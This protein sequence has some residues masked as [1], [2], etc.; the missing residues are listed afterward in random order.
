MN[1]KLSVIIPSNKEIFLKKTIEEL[2]TKSEED[3]EVI[4]V[5]DG[6]YPP[7]DEIIEDDR[8]IYLHMG[9]GGGMRRAIN[10]GVSIAK[11]NY[12]M[13]IDGHCMVDQGFDKKLKADCE[14]N[15][16]V[17]PRRKRLDA[18]LWT[19]QDVGKPDVDYEFISFP[20]W[21]PD[22]VGIHGTIWTERIV[23]RMNDPKYDIDE[24]PTFQGSCWFTTKKHFE[25]VIGEMQEEG[26]GS[27][28]GEPQ[29]ISMKTWL[30]GGKVM[31]NKK[32]WYAHLH[33]GKKYGR[34]YFIDKKELVAGNAYS[35]DYW[36]N[37]RFPK[38][39]HTMEWFVNEKFPDM[40]TWV[41]EWK[42]IC[43]KNGLIK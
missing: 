4:A 34:G 41:P 11:G 5:L 29:E 43:I 18:E 21:K 39:I 30:S 19:I 10:A 26:Y 38:A 33:K 2:L 15:W 40:P 31:I 12:I 1:N 36:M 7:A 9:A 14:E 32:T 20:Y 42:E 25:N 22:E 37:D 16:V 8:L 28:I 24:N 17:I 13:K 35:V 6:Y 3:I 23:A 27:F